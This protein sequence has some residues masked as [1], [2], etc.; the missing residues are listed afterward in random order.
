MILFVMSFP[1]IVQTFWIASSD[2][3]RNS[4]GYSFR[5]Y[6]K[7]VWKVHWD[8][9]LAAVLRMICN[10]A[11]DSLM[12]SFRTHPCLCLY[13]FLLNVSP[14]IL[15]KILPGIFLRTSSGVYQEIS[16]NNHLETGARVSLLSHFLLGCLKEFCRKFFQG[17]LHQFMLVLL[18]V[19]ISSHQ[20][21]I[22]QEIL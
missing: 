7:K 13:F 2:T 15:L 6:Q 1:K 5:I 21:A 19:L 8:K 12:Y 9:T 17:L 4:F 10:N 16:H 3:F 22:P 14:G 18:H 20:A 11:Q